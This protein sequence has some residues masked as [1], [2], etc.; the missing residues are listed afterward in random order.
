[1]TAP[2]DGAGTGRRRGTPVQRARVAGLR[3]ASWLARRLPDRVAIGL[4]DLAGD[5]WRRAAP[6]RREQAA[7]NL[8]RVASFLAERGAGPREARTA[9]QQPRDLNRLVREAFRH[10][11]RYYLEVLRVPSLTPAILDEQVT[12][13]RPHVV[14]DAF[15]GG[16]VIFASPHF[17]PIELPA[18][19]L[20]RRT[21]RT[22]VAPMEAVD[23]PPHQDWFEQT[24]GSLGVRIVGLRAARRELRA[25][26]ETDGYVGIVADRDVAG[27]GI[28]VPFFGR[29]APFPIGP[30]LLAIET[31]ARI[32]AVGVRRLPNGRYAGGLRHVPVAAE[33][34][35]RQRIEATLRE[36]A[37]AFEAIIAEAPEQWSGAFFPIWPDLAVGPTDVPK[38]TSARSNEAPPP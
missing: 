18:L 6:A 25:A 3:I 35:R 32:F 24:R 4:A 19:Y 29:P 16:P 17:G 28:E 34:S 10:D 8:A 26:L 27:G 22:F 11:A 12:V 33:G 5:A 38:P 37:A 7:R 30:A 2:A 1:V 21:G 13:E 9:A 14:E 31:G 15:S 20:A 23:D 36:L